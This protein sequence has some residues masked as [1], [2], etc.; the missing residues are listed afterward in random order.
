MNKLR[1]IILVTVIA[2]FANA[3]VDEPID[4]TIAGTWEVKDVVAGGQIPDDPFVVDS[5]L[6]LDPNETFLFVNVDGRAT[7]GTWATEG[8]TLSLTGNDEVEQNFIIMYYDWEKLHIF[9]TFTIVG[10][11]EVELRYLFR[12]LKGMDD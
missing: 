6:Y 7:G 11:A 4:P 9:R 8:D 10:G 3:C 1:N 2:F 12:R 5:R